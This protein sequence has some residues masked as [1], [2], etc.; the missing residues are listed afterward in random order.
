[1]APSQGMFVG[2]LLERS[3]VSPDKS[4]LSETGFLALCA[5][6]WFVGMVSV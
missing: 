1:M 3:I 4:C 2:G 5:N 6:R